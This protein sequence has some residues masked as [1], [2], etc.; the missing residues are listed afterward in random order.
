MK[1]TIK[2][3]GLMLL[4]GSMMLTSCSKGPY[5]INATANNDQ[6]GTVTG[7]GEFEKNAECTL[8]ATANAGY[9][10]VDWS[11][12]TTDNPYTFTAT[13]N[14]DLVANFMYNAKVNYD[15]SGAWYCNDLNIGISKS[16]GLTNF[17][18]C[19]DQND[20][21][22]PYAVLQCDA[23]SHLTVGTHVRRSGAEN[24]Q[25]FFYNRKGETFND[26][27]TNNP[28]APIWQTDNLTLTV[29]AFDANAK[30]MSI[31]ARGSVYNC[32]EWV[33]NDNNI[34]KDLVI[35]ATDCTWLQISFTKS[36]PEI[37]V[38]PRR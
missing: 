3:L 8:T 25:W 33:L 34:V 10:F 21:E 23:D 28:N 19:K 35:K 32:Q 36:A 12:G 16:S 14:I 13:K 9:T 20:S 27:E 1:N 31:E 29:N 38:T 11:D 7:T 6:R 24:F 26:T 30:S 22:A 18:F 15:N 17:E 37:K 4:C 5:T 2:I